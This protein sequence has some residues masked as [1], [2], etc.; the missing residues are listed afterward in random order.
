MILRQALSSRKYSVINIHGN[1]YDY[2]LKIN[3][4]IKEMNFSKRIIYDAQV[5]SNINKKNPL[6]N[7]IDWFNILLD[8]KYVNLK[9]NLKKIY[10]C[11]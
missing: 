11:L 9:I 5:S 8:K 6:S 4:V 7:S 1:N 10:L 2:H 3:K